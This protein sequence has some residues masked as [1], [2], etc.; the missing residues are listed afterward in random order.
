MRPSDSRSRTP[1][2]GSMPAPGNDD[3]QRGI[4]ERTRQR[5][6]E[7]EA[8]RRAHVVQEVGEPAAREPRPQQ[9][10]QERRRDDEQR[11]DREPED[12]LGARD[13]QQRE[14]QQADDAGDAREHGAAARPRRRA[15]A[16]PDHQR[17]REA[18]SRD[19]PLASRVQRQG[20]VLVRGEQQEVARQL[21]EGVHR[22]LQD[23]LEHERADQQA[24]ASAFE[25]AAGEEREQQRDHRDAP[26]VLEQVGHDQH[27]RRVDLAEHR[28]D[29]E[30]EAGGGHRACRR[31]C[32]GG[33]A[34]RPGRR[35]RTSRR[36]L[37]RRP[38]TPAAARRSRR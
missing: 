2:P 21:V 37:G 16:R 31:G 28:P 17:D 29:E 6:L 25:P 8:G 13:L 35:R 7:L 11:A 3:P 5:R 22:E 12:E 1:G 34:R 26:G 24:V 14:Q 23:E 27:G 38:S 15:P 36:P 18:G 20:Q 30:P 32:P 9:P 10:G 33:D 19:E 4:A